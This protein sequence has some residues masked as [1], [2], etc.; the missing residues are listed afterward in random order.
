MATTRT[1]NNDATS[2]L[3]VYGVAYVIAHSHLSHAERTFRL[4]RIWECSLEEEGMSRLSQGQ[5]ASDP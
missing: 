4:D 1:T 2:N 5:K 3:G